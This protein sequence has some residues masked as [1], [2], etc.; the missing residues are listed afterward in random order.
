MSAPFGA[1]FAPAEA[2]HVWSKPMSIISQLAGANRQSAMRARNHS[3]NSSPVAEIRDTF[4]KLFGEPAWVPGVEPQ[5]I[6]LPP[7]GQMLRVK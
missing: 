5:P 1:R 7:A 4:A 2:N 6:R 3:L